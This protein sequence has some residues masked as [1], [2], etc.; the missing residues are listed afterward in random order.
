MVD[1]VELSFA[2]NGGR[3]FRTQPPP[4]PPPP[5]TLLEADA[6]GNTK[7]KM[8]TTQGSGWTLNW[9]FDCAVLG[10]SGIFNVKIMR[11]DGKESANPP[12]EKINESDSGAEH[13]KQGGTFYL[14]VISECP[15][16]VRANG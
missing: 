7:T 10:D 11:Q 9:S 4:A 5:K 12:V 2:Q 3:F 16:H 1:V 14:D 6:N 15:W 8:F 13:Y